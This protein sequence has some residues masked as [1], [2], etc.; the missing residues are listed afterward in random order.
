MYTQSFAISV[1]SI[2]VINTPLPLRCDLVQGVAARVADMYGPLH[3]EHVT[4]STQ[5]P[6]RLLV[7]RGASVRSTRGM[8]I[9]MSRVDRTHSSEH[10]AIEVPALCLVSIVISTQGRACTEQLYAVPRFGLM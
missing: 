10:T 2:I 9:C 4:A 7:L 8:Y 1:T 5:Q 3:A 6:C